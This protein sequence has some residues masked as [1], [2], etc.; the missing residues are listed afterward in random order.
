MNSSEL[1]LRDDFKNYSETP[2]Y[3]FNKNKFHEIFKHFASFGQVYY[4]VKAN[5]RREILNEINILNGYYEV[6]NIY[7]INLLLHDI[8]VSPRK[9]Q[10]S[11][12][13]KIEDE[14]KTAIKMGVRQF[15]IDSIEEYQKIKKYSNGLSYIIRI[16]LKSLLNFSNKLYMKW[17]MPINEITNVKEI[18]EKDNNNFLGVSFYI[19]KEFYSANNFFKVLNVLKKQFSNT[20][21]E[22]LNIGGGLDNSLSFKFKTYL[23]DTKSALRAKTLILEPGRNLLN[24]CI[25][26][27]VSVV[28]VRRRFDL[29]WVYLDAGIYSGLLDKKLL[30]RKYEIIPINARKTVKPKVFH[31]AGPTSDHIDYIGKYTFTYDIQEGNKLL[32]KECGA[33]SDVFK[34]HFNGIRKISFR[35]I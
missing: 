25:D 15:V 9:I 16:S 17:G 22:I 11:I 26:L 23:E 1:H 6:D 24:P 33:Y 3:L 28:G 4:P 30:D 7:H 31:F 20:Y 12:P 21:F 32:I 35:T 13:V 18:I 8:K 10:F 34:T 2:C 14:I 29:T 19:P 5:D 27:L